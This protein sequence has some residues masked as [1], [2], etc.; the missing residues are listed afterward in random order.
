V[1][2]I[3]DYFIIAFY[4]AFILGV[5]FVFRRMSTNTSDYFRAGGAMPWWITGASSW[6]AG[7]SAWTFTGAAGM[8]YETG[9]VVLCLY[10]SAVVG[11]IIIYAWTCLRFR[12]MRVVAWMEAVRLRYGAASEQFYLWVTLPLLLFGSGVGLNAI[13]VFISSIFHVDMVT[14]LIVLGVIVTVVT[15]AGGAWAILA[16]DFVQMFLVVTITLLAAF[17]TLRL[18]QIGGISGLIEKVQVPLEPSHWSQLAQTFTIIPWI[19]AITW[20]QIINANNMSNATMY[21]MARTD[22][23]ARRMVLIP[24]IGS[25]ISPLI[26]IVPPLAATILHPDLGAEFPTLKQPHEAAFVAICLQVMPKGLM[27]LLISAMLGATLTSMDAGLNKGVGIFV[28]SFYLPIMNPKCP[29]KRLLI[30]SK[31]CTVAFGVIIVSLALMVNQFRTVNLFD[32]VNQVAA[33]LT[34]PLAI[35]LCFGLF[36]KRTPAWSAWSTG[37]VG[38]VVSFFVNFWVGHHFGDFVGPLTP[39][40]G[41]YLLLATTTFGTLFIA[42]G[43][44]FFTS[45]FYDASPAEHRARVEDFFHRLR[46][47]VEKEGVQ[48]V[49]EKIY[50]LLGT[51]CLVY[52]AFILLLTLIP[53]SFIGRMCFVFCGG[54]IFSAGAVLYLISRQIE[55]HPEIID[56]AEDRTLPHP[57]PSTTVPPSP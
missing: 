46:T 9:T 52:G 7:F 1:I 4:L 21:L 31:L 10:Y 23:D 37:L 13:G 27:G 47:P 40:E 54:T 39:R 22:R 6:V 50:R 41:T 16:S 25:L 53:N 38:F 45:L 36:F 24:I 28:R 2:S 30:V 11:M 34:I 44:Y 51:L 14:T 55:E 15:F 32:F 49:Q 26:W 42:G 57:P 56:T 5:G 17:L 48:D 33:S 18:P 19:L 29:E 12:R 43:W 20:M 35:P 3:Y 8:I